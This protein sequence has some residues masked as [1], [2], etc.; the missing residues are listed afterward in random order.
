MNSL[1]VRILTAVITFAIGVSVASL[2]LTRWTSNP[3]IA[4]VSTDIPAA[5][6]E[7][8][9]VLDTTGSMGG[10]LGAAKQRIWGIVNDVMQDSHSSVRVGLVAYRDR[11]D[12]YVTQ[13]LP[14]TE[15]LDKVYTT[16]MDYRA[17]GG[18]D[19]PE[20]VRTAL[21]EGLSKSGWSNAA[22]DL[23]QIIFLVGDAP[24]HEDYDAVDTL[25]TA[26][27]AVQKGII[28]N[29][30]QCGISG[31][32]ERAWQAIA[33]R[34]HGQYFAIAADGGVQAITTPY[35][36]QLGDLARTLG[37]TFL[38]YGFG[39]GAE[40]DAKRAEAVVLAER[41]EARVATSAPARAKAERAFNK[42][43]SSEAYVGDLL[44]QIE[45]G[46]VKLEAIDPA[47]L[48]EDMRALS[49]S[50][51]QQEIEKRLA[52]RREIRHQI[53]TLSKQRDAYIDAE[54][55]KSG[56]GDGFDVVVSKALKEQMSRKR[57]N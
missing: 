23:S 46:S 10:L 40:G 30:I 7:M 17:E 39:A 4:P 50:E 54:R 29:T 41:V 45:N 21:A 1:S 3:V 49:P 13:V 22:P 51:R 28:V 37:A 52:Q 48:T 53:L 35:D 25:T 15:D 47:Q 6:L 27:N 19:G 56:E 34:G 12:E 42:A 38:P 33:D 11:D 55:K 5:R 36:E 24:P 18:G 26:A 43:V 9:F 44:Q 32:T 2:W 14:L 16:L 20:D 8:V 57:I 31:E